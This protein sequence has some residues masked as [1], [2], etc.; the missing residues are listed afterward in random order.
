[1]IRLKDIA[2]Q[3]GVSVMTVSKALRG[4]GDISAT[5][6]A[7]IQALAKQMGYVP[8]SLAQGLRNRTTRLLG[9]VIPTV[10]NPI[11]ART[12]VAIEERAHELG[13]DLL[14][15][16]SLNNAEREEMCIQRLLSRRVEGLLIFPVYRL[17]PSSSVY[18]YIAHRKVPTVIL[19][20]RAAFCAQFPNVETDDSQGSYL[21]TQHLI[22]LGHRRIAFLC[23]PMSAPWA[24]DRL[25]GYRR[26][27]REAK[28]EPD[29]HLVFS[30]GSTVEEGEKAALQMLNEGTP[31]TAVQAVNDFTAIGAAG[32]LMNQGFKIPRDISIVGFGNIPA[33]EIFR[34]PLTTA[35]QAKLRLGVAGMEIMQQL[36]RGQRPDSRRLPSEIVARASSGAAPAV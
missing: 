2:S 19:G 29:D 27:L 31:P 10:A 33:A 16:H 34:V 11:Y 23:G 4:A 18:E 32:V 7:R 8:D 24:T 36:L 3:A 13:Y 35:R 22:G 1:M 26:A 6:K 12:L 28:I 15:A 20:Q 30:A 17:A 9:A 21:L 25:N 14:L 5:T